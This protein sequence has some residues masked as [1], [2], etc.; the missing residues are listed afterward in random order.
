MSSSVSLQ[1]CRVPDAISDEM[2][3]LIIVARC[4][5]LRHRLDALA[6]AG[7]DQSRHIKRAHLSPRLVTQAI[8]KRLEPTSKL[9]SP[10]RSRARHGRPSKSR[11][12][13][14]H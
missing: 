9:V 1:R 7:T 12:P 10:I 6:I 8:Q 5:S 14:N 3:Q 4:K 11:P 2:V 13:I